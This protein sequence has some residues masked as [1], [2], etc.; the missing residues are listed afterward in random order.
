[1]PILTNMC[2][3]SYN[4]C[5]VNCWEVVTLL[6]LAPENLLS[7]MQVD[8]KLQRRV[9]VWFWWLMVYRSVRALWDVSSECA[10][11]LQRLSKNLGSLQCTPMIVPRFWE[12]PK[13]P[14]RHCNV[15]LC[16]CRGFAA[17]AEV[18]RSIGAT[19]SL[20]HGVP[21]K[22]RYNGAMRCNWH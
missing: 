4:L 7:T 3:F 22:I 1:M 18:L 15:Y 8:G 5:Q 11:K 21:M 16:K 10:K 19:V 12:R 6:A 14:W 9:W 20:H 2:T 13:E 17:Y